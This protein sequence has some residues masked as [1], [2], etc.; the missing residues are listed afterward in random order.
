[1]EKLKVNTT[2]WLATKKFKG[3]VWRNVPGYE[4]FYEVS[5]W[6][7]VK[8]VKRVVG[9]KHIR[10][11]ILSQ[12]LNRQGYPVVSLTKDKINKYPAVHRLVAISFLP[13]PDNLPVVNHKDENP[14]NSNLDNL[15]WCDYSYNAN[16]G[17]RN[18]RISELLR[19]QP[20]RCKPVAQYD[21]DGNY[22][23]TWPSM[24]QVERELGKCKWAAV[25]SA[26]KGRNHTCIGSQWRIIKAGID[27]KQNIGGWRKKTK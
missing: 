27:H 5:N 20:S 2:H 16:Y 1:M 22:I 19:G 23:R 9:K 10:E 15:E 3:E 18:K 14:L 25:A 17:T 12:R 13:N 24:I 8:S 4:G 26:C 11:S 7:R 6:G 21:L